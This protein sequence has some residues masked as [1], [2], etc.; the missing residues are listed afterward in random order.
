MNQD[1]A[2]QMLGG[3]VRH[4]ITAFGVYLGTYGL[5]VSGSLQDQLYGFI[6][7][8]L[9]VV[10][11]LIS[12]KWAD[13]KKRTAEV[14]AAIASVEQ[15]VPVTVT[16]TAGNLPNETVKIS[17]DEIAK[18]PVAPINVPPSPAPA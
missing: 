16:V 9:P 6:M 18:A 13:R 7:A 3:L 15:G 4:G 1:L 17:P 10:W 11:S 2:L 12:K 5:T 14:A 8:S